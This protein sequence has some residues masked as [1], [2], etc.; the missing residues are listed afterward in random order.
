[1]EDKSRGKD[2]DKAYK[3]VLD[4]FPGL[5]DFELPK[6]VLVSDFAHFRLYDLLILILNFSSRICI[7][8]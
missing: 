3:Q 6:Y 7:R 2:L 8:M 5:K 1:M 4:Y